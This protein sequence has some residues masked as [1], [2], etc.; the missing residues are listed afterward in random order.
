MNRT[1][2]SLYRTAIVAF[3][4]LTIVA[5]SLSSAHQRRRV[6]DYWGRRYQNNRKPVVIQQHPFRPGLNATERL[7]HWN[8]IAIDASG[9]DH[10]PNQPGDTYLFGHQLGPGR[11]S[12]AMAIVHTAIFEAVNAIEG[13]YESYVGLEPVDKHASME[14]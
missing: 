7:R 14:C 5:T 3:L 8:E 9:L 10:T 1:N 13:K 4:L 12:R 11:A 6:E 2:S